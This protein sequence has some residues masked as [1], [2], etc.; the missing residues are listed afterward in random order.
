MAVVEL[1]A[2]NPMAAALALMHAERAVLRDPPAGFFPTTQE[3]ALAMARR[4]DLRPGLSVL[5]PSG[6]F[7]SLLDAC[8][9]LCPEATYETAE[10]AP[11]LRAILAAKGY[12]VLADDMYTLRASGRRWERIIANPD[13]TSAEDFRQTVEAVEHLLAPGGRYIG[14]VCALGLHRSDDLA[15]AFKQWLRSYDATV[16]RLGRDVFRNAARAANVPVA[17]ILI[18]KPG[19][20]RAASACTADTTPRARYDGK[21]A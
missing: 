17:R 13:F 14:L 20:P 11:E 19:L 7:G 10:R 16:V 5:D 21:P 15:E 8:R 3:C 9:Y 12:A 18:D 1:D 6:G 2:A 4:L